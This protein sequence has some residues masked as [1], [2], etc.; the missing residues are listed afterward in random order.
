MIIVPFIKSLLESE[1]QPRDDYR[2]CLELVLLVLGCPL[3]KKSS[4]KKPGAYHKARWMAPLIYGL[5]M[6]LF[7]FQISKNKKYHEKL[8]RFAIFASLFYAELWFRAPIA[9]DAPFMDLKLYKNM[10]KY[11]K[12]DLEVANAVLN[13]FLGHTWYLNQ[14]IVPFSLFSKNVSDREKAEIAKKLTKVIPPKK[15]EIGY[16]NPVPLATNATGLRRKLSDSVMNGSL[17]LFDELGFGKEWLNEPVSQWENHASFVEMKSWIHNL[18]VTNDCAE[19]GVKLISD[20][21]NILTKNPKDRQNLL[22]VVERQRERYPDV[23]KTTLAK[24]YFAS[25]K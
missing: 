19:R 15:Y 25:K 16:P 3:P 21:A 7:R 8:E 9:A 4:F 23:K 22:Q 14:E 1:K 12:I 6:F 13:K 18:K 11:K 5:K 20:F 2:E 17:F 24:N 10:L